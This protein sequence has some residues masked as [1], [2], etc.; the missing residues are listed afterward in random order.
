VRTYEYGEIHF[1]FGATEEGFPYRF[2]WSAGVGD[3][4][5]GVSW[6]EGVHRVAGNSEARAVG[7]ATYSVRHPA[8]VL[9]HL[10][11]RGWQVVHVNRSA[12]AAF[13]FLIY[14]LTRSSADTAPG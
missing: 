7:S 14:H 1:T 13:V 3:D 4:L 10:G 12:D 6:H 11:R 5:A 8:E 9:T 2:D